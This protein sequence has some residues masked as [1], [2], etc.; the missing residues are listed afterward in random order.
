MGLELGLK[1]RLRLGLGLGLRLGLRLR[2]QEEHRAGDASQLRPRGH[3]PACACTSVH[4][5]TGRINTRPPLLRLLL[6]LLRVN[7][8][9]WRATSE[10]ASLHWDTT[11]RTRTFL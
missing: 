3:R 8:P 11:E 6:L 7:W 5:I 9:S 10:L 2:L 1:L 4:R